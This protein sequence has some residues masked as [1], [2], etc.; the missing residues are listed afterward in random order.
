MTDW[1]AA[2][3][4]VFAARRSRRHAGAMLFVMEKDQQEV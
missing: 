4:D 1:G 3:Y 2:A